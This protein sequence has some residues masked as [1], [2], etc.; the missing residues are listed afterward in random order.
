MLTR[1]RTG[2]LT[3]KLF[4]D[5][6]TMT[7]TSVKASGKS[8]EE[9]LVLNK[10]GEITR[11][12]RGAI[13]VASSLVQ[14]SVYFKLGRLLQNVLSF[15]FF[16]LLGSHF[17]MHLSHTCNLKWAV[18][19]ACDLNRSCFSGHFM[20]SILGGL[21][22][23]TKIG[24]K[25]LPL[26]NRSK[27]DQR[28]DGQTCQPYELEERLLALHLGHSHVCPHMWHFHVWPQVT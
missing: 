6:I 7:T 15:V 22:L 18:V 27:H 9:V 26:W 20:V 1:S 21:G 17:G 19:P 14:Q 5:S 23:G 28:T 25:C 8:S 3:P 10:D 4:T 12:N 2:S 13:S 16:F 11:V 24:E